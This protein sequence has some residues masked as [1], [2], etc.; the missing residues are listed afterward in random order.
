MA[1][2]KCPPCR[3]PKSY[4]RAKIRCV[5]PIDRMHEC[6]GVAFQTS[7]GPVRLRLDIAQA[8]ALIGAILGYAL[9]VTDRDVRDGMRAYAIRSHCNTDAGMPR[10]EVSK[11]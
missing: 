6:L 10:R 4:R 11:R 7:A 2:P 5:L 3:I 1:K 8:S 9:G